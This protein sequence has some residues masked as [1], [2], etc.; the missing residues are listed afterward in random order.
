MKIRNNNSVVIKYT[1][2]GVIFG[3]IFPCLSTSI[4]IVNQ[5]L[6]FKFSSFLLVQ[7]QN[8]LMLIIDSALLVLG[9]FGYQVGIRQQKLLDQADHL[10]DLVT[11]RSDDILR[12][13][14]FYEALVE[15]SPVAITTLDQD[16]RVTDCVSI[17]L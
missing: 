5:H 17:F 4:E 16:H 1:T 6:P 8:P 3:I 15:N 2:A 13:K 9:Y 12:Q 7:Q 10:E 11:K 14:L